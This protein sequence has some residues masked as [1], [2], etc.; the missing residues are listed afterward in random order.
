MAIGM[1]TLTAQDGKKKVFA[2]QELHDA[3]AEHAEVEINVVRVD[4]RHGKLE[5]MLQVVTDQ[6]ER[7]LR[8]HTDLPADT[9]FEKDGMEEIHK[10]WMQDY[11][12]WMSP[13]KVREWYCRSWKR[14]DHKWAHQI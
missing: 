1:T 12:S 5:A 4:P 9:V 10:Q 13:D 14:G 6:R 7:H 11:Y 3:I 2:L 8:R